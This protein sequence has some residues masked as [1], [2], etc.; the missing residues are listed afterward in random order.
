MRKLIV[1]LRE[2]ITRL[3]TLQH[4]NI[5]RDIDQFYY[6][7]KAEEL[8]FLCEQIIEAEQRKQRAEEMLRTAYKAVALRWRHDLRVLVRYKKKVAEN[9]PIL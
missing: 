2:L 4:L 3:M 1:K 5:H 6:M 8:E 9:R 7:Q